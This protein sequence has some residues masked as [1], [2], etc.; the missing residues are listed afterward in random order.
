MGVMEGFGWLLPFYVL[1]AN[2]EQLLHVMV[3]E[4]VI[5]VPTLFARFNQAHLAQAAQLMR[6]RRLG[7]I[8]QAGDVVDTQFMVHQHRNDL[9]AVAIAHRPEQ[10]RQVDRRI[11]VEQV[12]GR[13][14]LLA[15]VGFATGMGLHIFGL[16]FFGLHVCQHVIA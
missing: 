5:D 6:H 9:H 16:N 1:Q 12:V 7:H 2:L 15:F 3:I 8:H 4:R 10:L 11:I 14:V 13:R